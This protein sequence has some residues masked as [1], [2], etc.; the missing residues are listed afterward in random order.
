MST[1]NTNIGTS[2]TAA[3][4]S[5]AASTTISSSAGAIPAPA[6]DTAASSAHSTGIVIAAAVTWCL[7]FITLVCIVLYFK[8]KYIIKGLSKLAGMQIDD[9][10]AIEE[11]KEPR[12]L[13]PTPFHDARL[14][15][16]TAAEAQLAAPE[17]ARCVATESLPSALQT[18]PW[19]PASQ[20]RSEAARY[21][22]TESLRP[23]LQTCPWLPT[24]QFRP[25]KAMASNLQCPEGEADDDGF[26]M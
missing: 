21:I 17:A 19:Q 12:L 23:A 3:V 22:A 5:R 10:G 4:A 20:L 26:E 9:E 11:A 24:S 6:L 2:S 15:E 16:G 1:M 14:A 13:S 7:C 8:R 25:P 18:C